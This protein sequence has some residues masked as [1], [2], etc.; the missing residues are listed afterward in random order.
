MRPKINVS[1][2]V[3]QM[4]ILSLNIFPTYAKGESAE[5]HYYDS[6]GNSLEKFDIIWTKLHD[7]YGQ[8]ELKQFF[9]EIGKIKDLDLAFKKLFGKSKRDIEYEW[10]QYLSQSKIDIESARPRILKM[11]PD[12]GMKNVSTK[13]NEIY[14]EFN[15]KMN[16]NICINTPCGDTGICYKNA[17]WKT[18]KILVIKVKNELRAQYS[19]NLVLSPHQ[20]CQL[21]SSTGIGFPLKHWA[22]RTQ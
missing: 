12:H 20:K 2:I 11:H 17:Y 8:L 15:K 19:Y 7:Y 5:R 3:I 4:F 14:V 1:V 16:G 13:L 21:R 9:L 22:F 6:Y 18:E 10:G